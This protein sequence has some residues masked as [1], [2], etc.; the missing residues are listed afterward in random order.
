MKFMREK[1]I[2]KLASEEY[3]RRFGHA[4]MISLLIIEILTYRGKD[5]AYN[6]H[7][8][9]NGEERQMVQFIT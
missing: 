3:A 2:A 5:L 7:F 4:G 1:I 6:Y 9:K 8:G